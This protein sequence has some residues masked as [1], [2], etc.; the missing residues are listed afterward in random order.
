MRRLE[1]EDSVLPENDL[2]EQVLRDIGLEYT[3]KCAMNVQ[4]YYKRQGLHM[5]LNTS[6]QQFVMRLNDLNP[7]L[8]H[9]PEENPK[10]LD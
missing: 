10:Q 6:V 5:R 3:P 4:K 9:F 2:I 7:Y 1:A 8:L